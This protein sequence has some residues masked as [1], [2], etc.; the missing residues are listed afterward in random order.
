MSPAVLPSASPGTKILNR[1]TGTAASFAV[2]WKGQYRIDGPAFVSVD[3]ATGR[4]TTIFGYPRQKITQA[5]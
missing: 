3:R 4:L 2:E 1:P 5:E